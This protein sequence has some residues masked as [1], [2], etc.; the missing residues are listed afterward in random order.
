MIGNTERH[1]HNS[2]TLVLQTSLGLLVL[3]KFVRFYF[4]STLSIF[5]AFTN[6]INK[7]TDAFLGILL[8]NCHMVHLQS[9]ES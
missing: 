2:A 7:Y 1:H 3:Q 6:N 8:G 9:L 5:Y 4:F